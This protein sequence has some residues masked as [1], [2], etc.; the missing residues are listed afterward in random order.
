MRDDPTEV[1]ADWV[2]G[3]IIVAPTTVVMVVYGPRGHGCSIVN[4]SPHAVMVVWRSSQCDSVNRYMRQPWGVS[5]W[6]ID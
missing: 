6:S 3:T 4:P 1:R 5:I 2:G